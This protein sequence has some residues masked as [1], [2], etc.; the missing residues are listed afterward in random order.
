[1]NNI[2]TVAHTVAG[3]LLAAG[4]TCAFRAWPQV[5]RPALLCGRRLRPAPS[6]NGDFPINYRLHRPSANQF[7]CSLTFVTPRWAGG[8][9]NYEAGNFWFVAIGSRRISYQLD[10]QHISVRRGG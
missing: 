7:R 4:E 1:V 9:A 3:G 2:R 6:P 10:N 5:S 8:G